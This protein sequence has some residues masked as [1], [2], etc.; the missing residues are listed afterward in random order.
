MNFKE[1]HI[2]SVINQ[3]ITESEI[4]MSRICN[5]LDCSEKDVKDMLKSES[6]DANLLLKWS[7][8]LKYDLFRIYNQHLILFSPSSTKRTVSKND[9]ST[10]P[11]FRKNIYT[12]EIIDFVLGLIDSREKTIQQVITDYNIPK[13]TLHKWISKYKQSEDKK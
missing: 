8:L 2:G 4:G 9:R 10:L 3:C 13:T 12:R 1:I 11:Q 6:L 7:K 5:F